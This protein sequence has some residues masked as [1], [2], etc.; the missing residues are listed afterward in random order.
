[1]GTL[2]VAATGGHLLELHRLRPRLLAESEPV[3]W[4]TFDTEQSRSLLAG[5]HVLMVRPVAP[6]DVRGVALSVPVARRILRD[7]RAEQ[8]IS[9]GAAVAVAFLPL[10]RASGLATHYIESA[11]RVSGPS[12]TGRLLQVLRAGRL[13]AQH[14]SW[15][16][17]RWHYR[18]SVF[19]AAAAVPVDPAPPLRRVLVTLGTMRFP[20]ALLVQRL[21]AVLPPDVDI[22]WQ[23]G[24]TRA[25]DVPG[26]VHGSLAHADLTAEMAAADVVVSHAGVGSALTALSA[27]R[28]PVLVP[29]R[30]HRGEHVDDHQVPTAQTLQARGLGV[31][32]DAETLELADLQRA[33]AV[34]IVDVEAPPFELDPMPVRAAGRRA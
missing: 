19:D 13:Y 27:G 20:F 32:A 9:T 4:V 25:D 1:M 29:R 16:D 7:T 11:A 2:L 31:A 26:R 12:M 21:R 34:R 8:V 3:T 30:A 6:R 22:V 14:P 33:A 23:T 17:D 18:G 28:C 24:G 5:E 10:A 15:A